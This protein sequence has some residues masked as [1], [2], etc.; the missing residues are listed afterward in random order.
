MPTPSRLESLYDNPDAKS[1]HLEKSKIAVLE[2]QH[3][4]EAEARR[5]AQRR[6]LAELDE[7]HQ[8][9]AAKMGSYRLPERVRRQHKDERDALRK[10]HQEKAD[11]LAERHDRE[12][13]AAREA[14]S[15]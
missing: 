5:D 2:A 8:A 14:A 10:A 1:R 15:I 7:R 9:E 4:C 12:M 13:K 3:H 6:A 11:K